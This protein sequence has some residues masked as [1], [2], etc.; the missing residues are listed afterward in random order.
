MTTKY[1]HWL[2]NQTELDRV[3][4]MNISQGVDLELQKLESKNGKNTRK[5]TN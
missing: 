3:D 5:R 4:S 2:Y 1:F